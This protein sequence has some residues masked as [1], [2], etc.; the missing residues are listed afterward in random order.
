M[1]S[2]LIFPCHCVELWRD[3]VQMEIRRIE[4]SVGW[5]EMAGEAN[6]PAEFK[7]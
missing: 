1:E 6:P 7:T 3:G 5:V 4:M 2:G